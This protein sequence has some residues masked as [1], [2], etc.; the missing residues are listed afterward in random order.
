MSFFCHTAFK[1][2]ELIWGNIRLL[3][4]L[5]GEASGMQAFV[6]FNNGLLQVL[7]Q[8]RFGATSFAAGDVFVT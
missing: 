4:I 7:E 5:Q 8:V 2:R 1:A 3:L 6:L